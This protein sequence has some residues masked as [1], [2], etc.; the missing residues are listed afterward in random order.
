MLRLMNYMNQTK[1]HRQF[2]PVGNQIE[3]CKLG[4]FQDALFAGDL[5]DSKST[6]GGLLCV[7]GSHT[8]VPIPWMCQRQTA[9]SH[10]MKLFRLTQVYVW[11]VYQLYNWVSVCWE[12]F[13]AKQ[14][15]ETLSVINAIG[16]FRLISIL[17]IVCVSPLTVFRP[18]IPDSS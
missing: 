3:D 17:R 15:R 5:R 2:C 12:H 13:P 16:S 9:V 10:S 14:P 4:L 1:N 11:M 6:S 8:F 18:N 7:L